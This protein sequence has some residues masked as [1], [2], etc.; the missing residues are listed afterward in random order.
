MFEEIKP[1]QYVWSKQSDRES[2][3]GCPGPW[4]PHSVFSRSSPARAVM[5]TELGR[6]K[7]LGLG[8]PWWRSR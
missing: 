4:E 5:G 8:L 3:A 6:Q 1:G 7:D 2:G